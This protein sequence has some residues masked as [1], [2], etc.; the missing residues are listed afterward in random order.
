MCVGLMYV[1]CVCFVSK[2]LYRMASGWVLHQL[3]QG[4]ERN[5]V[6]KQ[7]RL[8]LLDLTG[9]ETSITSPGTRLDTLRNHFLQL[10]HFISHS[11]L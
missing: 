10:L 1:V 6:S 7:S 2:C 3:H 4:S 9:L 8:V 11:M 5:V